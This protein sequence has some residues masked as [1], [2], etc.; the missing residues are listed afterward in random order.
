MAGCDP[1][2]TAASDRRRIIRRRIGTI[3]VVLFVV[4]ALT[5]TFAGAMYAG[6]PTESWLSFFLSG[7]VFSVPLMSI[8]L[9]HEMGHYL[10]GRRRYLDITPP[11]FLPSVP[12]LGTFGAF[13]KIRSPI[14]TKKV[15]VEVGASGPIA[16]AALAI[17]LLAV[18]LYHSEIRPEAIQTDGLGLTFGSSLILELICLLRF[19]QF[20]FN[21]TILMHPTAMAAWFGLFVT[22]MNLLPMGQLDGG[23]VIYALFGERRARMISF[24]T[25][26]CMIPLGIFFWQGWLVFGVLALFLGL[27]H[28]PPL[29]PYTPL[30]RRGKILGWVAVVLFILTIVPIPITIAD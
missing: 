23:H 9:V 24:A 29:D 22:A 20:S 16:G 4:T 25:F 14:P 17:P 3:N 11:Y 1:F 8:L 18:G 2:A 27:K 6:E 7:W 30:D 13:I 15:L 10:A 12:P 5:T 28:P 19:G 26:A 21:S